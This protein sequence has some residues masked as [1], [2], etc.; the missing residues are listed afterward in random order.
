MYF[1]GVDSDS[2][3]IDDPSNGCITINP[4]LFIRVFQ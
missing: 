2:V 4:E 3:T 1:S